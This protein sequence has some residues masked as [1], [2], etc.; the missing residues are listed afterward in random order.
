MGGEKG[1]NLPPIDS[2]HLRQGGADIIHSSRH[3]YN[4][5]NGQM[6]S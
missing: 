4:L 5:N 2:R 1:L 3:H 6:Q